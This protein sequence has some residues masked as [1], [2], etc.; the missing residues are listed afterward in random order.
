MSLTFGRWYGFVVLVGAATALSATGYLAHSVFFSLAAL[1]VAVPACW[2]QLWPRLN[3]GRPFSIE[4]TTST[5]TV[6]KDGETTRY[7]STN[8]FRIS[9]DGK[10]LKVSDWDERPLEPLS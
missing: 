8:G 10:S 3:D 9:R 6:T 7:R 4:R 5:V 1:A 2:S